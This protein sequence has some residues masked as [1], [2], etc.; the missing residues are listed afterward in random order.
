MDPQLKILININN[1]QI[2]S[3]I[4][5]TQLFIKMFNFINIFRNL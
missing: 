4:F 1:G 2:T 3:K 5:K